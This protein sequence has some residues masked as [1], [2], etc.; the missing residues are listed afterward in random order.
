MN[1]RF[2]STKVLKRRFLKGVEQEFL[3]IT[4]PNKE[5]G[6]R[7]TTAAMQPVKANSKKHKNGVLLVSVRLG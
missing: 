2:F 5:R 6:P 7:D 1:S 4:F 3:K